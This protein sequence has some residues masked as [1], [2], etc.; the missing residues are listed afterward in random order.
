VLDTIELVNYVF[1]KIKNIYK[2][3]LQFD[4]YSYILLEL[5]KGDE[6]GSC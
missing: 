5:A 2:R 4:N 1:E 3:G 6:V